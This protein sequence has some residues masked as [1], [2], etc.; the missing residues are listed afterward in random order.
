MSKIEKPP[1]LSPRLTYSFINLIGDQIVDTF[2]SD[3]GQ[4]LAASEKYIHHKYMYDTA[5]SDI[6][7]K[8]TQ[9]KN[10]YPAYAEIEILTRF[11]PEIAAKLADNTALIELGSGSATKTRWLLEA[12]L[13]KQGRTLFCPIDI[14]GDFLQENVKRLSSEYPNLEILAI[15]ADYYVGLATL[16]NRIQQP[17]LLLWLGSDIG[18]TDRS[19]AAKLLR[20][21][22]LPALQPGDKLLL[23][24]DLKK[25]AEPINLAYGCPGDNEPLRYS[26]NCN[27]LRRIN[28]QL[29]G[30]FIT[31]NFQRYCFYNEAEG[32][33]EIYLKSLCD[34]Q[35]ALTALDQTFAFKTAELIRIH[36][37]HKYD[38]ADIVQL[39]NAAGLTLEHQWFDNNHWYSLNLFTVGRP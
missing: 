6:F 11:A 35:V 37:A 33:V 30:N 12:L 17:K 4:G 19:E 25:A 18:H 9:D 23:G 13:Q 34:Q 20:E 21:K 3:I 27:A 14:S 2:D 16:A 7:E 10:Y 22:M 8:I 38:Q 28:Q 5:G 15:I 36:F 31:D 24:I 26:F 39:A 29:G 1:I 32:R